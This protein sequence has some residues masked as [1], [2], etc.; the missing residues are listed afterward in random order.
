MKDGWKADRMGF[1]NDPYTPAQMRIDAEDVIAREKSNGD[2]LISARRNRLIVEER[3]SIPLTKD[4]SY[5]KEGSVGLTVLT[6]VTATASS[7]DATS[8]QLN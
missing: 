3:L 7:S 1:S 5:E 6:T 8:S 4:S 2:L